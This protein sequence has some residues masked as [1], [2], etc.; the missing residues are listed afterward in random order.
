LFWSREKTGEVARLWW[1]ET[2]EVQYRNRVREAVD[3]GAGITE[4]GRDIKVAG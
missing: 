1:T 3:E 4:G 2:R